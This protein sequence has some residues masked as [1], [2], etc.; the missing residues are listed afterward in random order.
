MDIDMWP[1]I[2][3]P[4]NPDS[5][6]FLLNLFVQPITQQLFSILEVRFFLCLFVFAALKMN[7]NIAQ[8]DKY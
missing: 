8:L 4:E 7:V 2:M 5:T 3:F 6:D 1:G